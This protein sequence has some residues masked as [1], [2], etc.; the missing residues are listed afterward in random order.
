MNCQH[1]SVRF[2]DFA[3]IVV[4]HYRVA[5]TYDF[6]D[7]LEIH[8]QLWYILDIIWIHVFRYFLHIAWFLKDRL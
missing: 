4:K 3:S 5:L 8:R 6:A 7:G 2:D 1:V